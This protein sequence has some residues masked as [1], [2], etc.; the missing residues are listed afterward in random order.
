MEATAPSRR[1]RICGATVQRVFHPIAVHFKGSGVYN[2]N[3]GTS[4]R[5]R[6]MDA[7][8]KAGADKRRREE[9]GQEGLL[10]VSPR[11]LKLRIVE[12]LV[13]SDSGGSGSSGNAD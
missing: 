2:T 5:K 8:A 10:V 11:G 6:E 13:G 12:G 9:R 3:Y 1:A 7:S 4:K